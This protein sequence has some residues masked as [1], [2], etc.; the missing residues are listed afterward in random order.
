MNELSRRHFNKGLLMTGATAAAG[1]TLPLSSSSAYSM[2]KEVE[3]FK[4][5]V[6]T[7][8][9]NYPIWKGELPAI[10][11]P[12]LLS[13]DMGVH[14][15]EWGS[16]TFRDLKGGGREDLFKAAPRQVFKDLRKAADDA[17][18]KNEILSAGG[19][20]YLGHTEEKGR[21]EALNFFMQWVEPAQI[22]GC[23]A[24]RVEIY[25]NTPHN[26]TRHQ[27]A[28]NL[29]AEG[30]HQLLEKTKDSGLKIYLENH[31]G[32]SSQAPWLVDLIKIVDNPRL[33]LTADTNNFRTDMDLPYERD[34]NRLP[35]YADRYEGLE[36]LMPL[37]SWVSAKTYTFDSTGYEIALNY[38]RIID[39]ILKS[40]YRGHLSIEYE[41]AGDPIE[42]VRQSVK[43]FNMLREHFSKEYIS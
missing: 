20:F 4:L 39:I 37:A 42:G 6:M 21:Q 41:G 22:L 15:I 26:E 32:I 33:G 43:M 5:A 36:V 25:T 40:G 3:L 9:F 24:I 10:Q 1:L 14:A 2:M 23:R 13:R 17:G 18:V 19:P 29:C 35:E 11:I 7:W 31:H 16:K 12:E 8:S 38:P 27:D 28:L 34:F 30:L